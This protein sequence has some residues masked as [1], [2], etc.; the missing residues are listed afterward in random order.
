MNNL[1][2]I[3]TDKPSF[4]RSKALSLFIEQLG[5]DKDTE[6]YSI[7]HPTEDNDRRDFKY[8]NFRIIT[9]I[10]GAYIFYHFLYEKFVDNNLNHL[11][12]ASGYCFK[13]SEIKDDLVLFEKQV[14]R[15]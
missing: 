9:R 4:G 13:A 3:S 1:H 6:I 15:L 10:D 8:K 11:S 14:L 7:N 2:L 12:L 5:I